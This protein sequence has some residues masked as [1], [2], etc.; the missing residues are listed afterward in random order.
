[1][2]AFLIADEY[3]LLDSPI[4]AWPLATIA[5]LTTCVA[6]TLSTGKAEV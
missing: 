5:T 2:I 1:M 4:V 6:I 3:S